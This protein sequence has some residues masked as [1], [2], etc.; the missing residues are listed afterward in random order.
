MVEISLKRIDSRSFLQVGQECVE[1]SD[2]QVKSSADGATELLITI[3]G[4]S[5]VFELS[6]S[7]I[8]QMQ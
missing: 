7:L 6:A 4:T 1:I 2:Y 5:E 3:T 8:E